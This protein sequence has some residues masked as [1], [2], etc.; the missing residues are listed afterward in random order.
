MT[1]FNQLG[2]KCLNNF[3]VSANAGIV[4]TLACTN[5][6]NAG[7]A[8]AVISATTGGEVAG[9]PYY[10]A[11]LSTGPTWSWGLDNSSLNKFVI[12]Y[13][14][15][16]G[17]ANDIMRA[18]VSGAINYPLQPMSMA[19]LSV[20]LA[21][22][23]G[24]NTPVEPIVFDAVEYD[25]SGSYDNATGYFTCPVDGIYLIKGYLTLNNLDA[26]HILEASSIVRNFANLFLKQSNPWPTAYSFLGQSSNNMLYT[27]CTS[28]VVGDQLS[29]G[30]TVGG[31]TKT[32]DIMGGIQR[33]HFSVNLLG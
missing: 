9:D 6:S 20:T 15:T 31:G 28:C 11:S 29:V 12:S 4:R 16:L 5:Y 21:N 18:Y 10:K 8:T 17:T 26:A 19:Y 13:D 33:S 7:G 30:M 22:A 1:T 14:T 23:T 25:Q 32:V 24:D 3:T 27:I 2:N